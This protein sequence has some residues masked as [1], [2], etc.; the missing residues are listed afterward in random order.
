MTIR[1]ITIAALVA[2]IA[3][4]LVVPG[5]ASLMV[6]VLFLGGTNVHTDTHGYT[7]KHPAPASGTGQWAVAKIH[8]PA[9]SG[10]N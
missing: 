1:I 3:L 9:V 5:Y 7:S 8:G 2:V 10:T 4:S 6:I